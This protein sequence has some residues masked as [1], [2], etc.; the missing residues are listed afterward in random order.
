MTIHKSKDNTML[1]CEPV[2]LFVCCTKTV[3]PVDIFQIHNKWYIVPENS[4]NL[5]KTHIYLF[6]WFFSFLLLLVIL[7][8]HFLFFPLW[9]LWFI[10]PACYHTS[11]WP[12]SFHFL[13]R[14][15]SARTSFFRLASPTQ[16]I[17]SYS[18]QNCI[19]E[20]FWS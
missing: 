10:F 2:W 12:L 17:S 20:F 9:F 11:F 6:L 5:P 14:S 8:C 18:W 7:S 1:L 3:L 19:A 4:R 15:Q 16:G 13:R